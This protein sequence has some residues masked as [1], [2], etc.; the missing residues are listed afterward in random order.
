MRA[1]LLAL[2][3]LL[4]STAGATAATWSAKDPR[5]DVRG[6]R[7]QVD[8][9]ARRKACDGPHGYRVPDDR[10][11][12]ITSLTVD[13]GSDLVVLTLGM[14]DV[15]RPDANTSYYLHVRTPTAAYQLYVM[16]GVDPLPGGDDPGVYVFFSEEPDF[17]APGEIKDCQFATT[18]LGLPCDGLVGDV[19]VRLDEVRVTIPRRCLRDPRWVR[20]AAE[21]SGSTR[22]TRAGH[23]TIFS[24]FW[25]PRGVQRHGFLPPFGPRVHSG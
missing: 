10:R 8:V 24:D 11:R 23:L 7:I 14:R 5:A 19:D 6:I 1:V 25:A 16:R 20:V 17:P 22:L 12:D 21:S 9:A 2:T 4:T 3:L 15:T 18:S 13:H